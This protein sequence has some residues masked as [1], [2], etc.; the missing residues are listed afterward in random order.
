MPDDVNAALARIISDIAENRS[1]IAESRNVLA[2]EIGE[3]RQILRDE[4]ADTRQILRGEIAETRQVLSLEIVNTRWA[5]EER[6]DAVDRKLD[7]FR[8]ETLANFDSVFLRL[9]RL[10]SEYYAISAALV[11]VEKMISEERYERKELQK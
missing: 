9:E 5:L 1:E 4:I 11:R 3:T 8:E 6:V 10:E 2:R 7:S